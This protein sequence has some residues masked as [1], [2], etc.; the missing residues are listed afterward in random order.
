MNETTLIFVNSVGV[1]LFSLYCI[2]FYVFT[3]NKRRM[4]HQLILVILMIAF[5]VAYSQFEPDNLQASR[6][7]GITSY[8]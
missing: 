3:V 7:I 2:S 5:S 4:S 6:L 8:Q 1:C